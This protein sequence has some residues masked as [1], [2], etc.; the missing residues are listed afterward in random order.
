M[1]SLLD[2]ELIFITGKGGVGK[3]T[4]AAAI[5]L[6]AA[7]SGRRV[8]VAEV[9]DQSRLP[10]IFHRQG[11]TAG[12]ELQLQDGLSSITIDPDR[13]LLEWLQ[14]VGGR[15]SGRILASSGT[16]QYFAAAA[17]GAQELVSMV[18]IW[19]LTRGARDR[20]ARHDLV[21][22]D[23][24]AT[25]H[26]LG[27]LSSPQTFG[28]IARVGPIAGQTQ[29]VRDMLAD[30][31]RT[32]YVAVALGT[33]MAVTE[34]LEVQEGLGRQLGRSLTA[35]IVNGLM[36]RRFSSAEMGQI[37]KLGALAPPV[38]GTLSAG[39]SNGHAGAAAVRQ[40]AA[41]AARSIDSRS[42]T[43]HNQMA[44]L[45]R[46]DFDVYGIPFHWGERVD[47]QA[48]RH[49]ADGLARKLESQPGAS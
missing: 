2:R 47:L 39:A 16:F 7:A 43:Q 20:R 6:A 24:P 26:A 33:E 36:P 23:A 29:Q 31:A 41:R 49:I 21:V 48:L 35:V 1:Q 18:K 38:P 15:V 17:P 42:R 9:G 30:P 13:A 44:R 25:G 11:S 40:A 37:S 34:A 8:I 27:M 12:A 32:A 5:G 19:Q 28:A 45:R 10:A 46:R 22:V 14:S 4:M 3:T